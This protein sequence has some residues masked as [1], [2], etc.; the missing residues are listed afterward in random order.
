M[1][2]RAGGDSFSLESRILKLRF[3]VNVSVNVNVNV[4]EETVS[5]MTA[6]R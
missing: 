5:L 4:N 1:G 6:K 2:G 3:F